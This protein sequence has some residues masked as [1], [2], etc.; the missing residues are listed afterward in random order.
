VTPARADAKA[1]GTIRTKSAVG[2]AGRGPSFELQIDFKEPP[3]ICCPAMKGKATIKGKEL[4]DVVLVPSTAVA[5]QGGKCTLT[6]SK[7]GKTASREGHGRKS[8]GKMHP[9][10]VGP[11][12]RREGD[13]PK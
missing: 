5:A 12:G 4:K 11:R 10:Q 13:V 9:D 7:D 1:E 2:P 8:D 3:P 6:V